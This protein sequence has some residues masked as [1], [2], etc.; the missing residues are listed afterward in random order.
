MSHF[1]STSCC[2]LGELSSISRGG[3]ARK[4]DP[5]EAL[6][7]AFRSQHSTHLP[8]RG[9]LFF[10][11][12]GRGTYGKKLK[13]YIEEQGLGEVMVTKDIH[14]P[15]H[16]RRKTGI[17]VF[18]WTLNRPKLEEWVKTNVT[19]PPRATWYY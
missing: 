9:A 14:N 1:G 6:A 2:G 15:N 17:R 5:K 13:K 10:T 19:L 8:N 7:G 4:F 3:P 12:G 11:E 16:P 18:I